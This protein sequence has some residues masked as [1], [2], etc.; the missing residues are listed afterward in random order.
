MLVFHCLIRKFGGPETL[1]GLRSPWPSIRGPYF[2]IT[3]PY[4]PGWP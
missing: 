1:C 4:Y 3:V 2:L